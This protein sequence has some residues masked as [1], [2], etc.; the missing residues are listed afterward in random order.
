MGSR[1]RQ[2]GEA[3]PR[4]PHGERDAAQG[5]DDAMGIVLVQPFGNLWVVSEL[6]H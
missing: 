4:R 2:E 3:I 6:G 1:E 5:R